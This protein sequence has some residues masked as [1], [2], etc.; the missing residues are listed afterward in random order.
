[1]H[2]RDFVSEKSSSPALNSSTLSSQDLYISIDSPLFMLKRYELPS[3][4]SDRTL[5]NFSAH[6][7]PT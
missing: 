6:S 7:M 2:Q 1:M 4:D 5:N 3:L